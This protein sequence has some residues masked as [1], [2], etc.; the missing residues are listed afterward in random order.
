ML[1]SPA[2]SGHGGTDLHT[3]LTP[4][5]AASPASGHGTGTFAIQRI[6]AGALVATFGG[7]STDWVG[8]SLVEPER[9]A[10]SLQVDDDRFLV[11]PPSAEPG[12]QVNHS[13][14]PTCRFRN[15]VQLVAWRDLEPGDELT[16]DYATTDC[17]PY[18]EFDC[19]CGSPSCRGRV[20]ADD[21][22]DREVRRRLDGAFSPHVARRI[23][24]LARARPLGKREVTDLLDR[25]DHDPVAALEVALR[26]C[27]G[28]V[29]GDWP[30]LVARLSP[31]LAQRA[32]LLARET[33]ALD[34][35]AG[36]L[37][38]ARTAPGHPA[39]DRGR[40]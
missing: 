5:A 37:N 24:D 40:D 6:P 7:A 35:L 21:W 31:R 22:S 39:V 17:A 26:A 3:L 14:A 8:L 30:R 18:D 23:R 15:A 34:W 36:V 4:S 13:C 12:E 16:Y 2:P 10:R 32:G 19:R 25:Y 1:S 20:R 27:T 11:G 29:H 9:R 38:E 33:S 28:F